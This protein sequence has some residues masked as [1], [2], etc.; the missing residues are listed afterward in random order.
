MNLNSPYLSL[1]MF[2]IFEFREVLRAHLLG[3]KFQLYS[4][5][6][7]AMELVSLSQYIPVKIGMITKI[8]CT[9]IIG[10]EVCKVKMCKRG[11]M[12]I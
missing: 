7:A 2:S 5:I 11:D 4:F 8:V 10:L 3:N 9:I 6:P 1:A 12:G